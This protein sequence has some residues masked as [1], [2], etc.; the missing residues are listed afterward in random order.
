MGQRFSL[1]PSLDAAGMTSQ[2]IVGAPDGTLNL[3]EELSQSGGCGEQCFSR[4]KHGP[5]HC[6]RTTIRARKN[7]LSLRFKNWPLLPK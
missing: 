2:S 5:D 4:I 1:R 7:S 3:Y 6:V